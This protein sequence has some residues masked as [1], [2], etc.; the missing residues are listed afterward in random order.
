MTYSWQNADGEPIMSGEAWRFEQQ[1]DMDSQ[2]DYYA[3][4]FYDNDGDADECDDPNHECVDCEHA[5]DGWECSYCGRKCDPHEHD[6]DAYYDG[7]ED[8][9]LDGSYEE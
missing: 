2:A 9:W 8:Q 7:M 4:H 1:L 5:S 6:E 3:D